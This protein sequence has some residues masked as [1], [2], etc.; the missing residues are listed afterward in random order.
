MFLFLLPLG[1]VCYIS[2]KKN[3]PLTEIFLVYIVFRLIVRLILL[4][5]GIFLGV[6]AYDPTLYITYIDKLYKNSEEDYKLGFAVIVLIFTYLF[7]IKK[8]SAYVLLSTLPLGPL[9]IKAVGD[10]MFVP[11]SLLSTTFIGEESLSQKG[12]IK[13]RLLEGRYGHTYFKGKQGNLIH[14][15]FI[16]K[17]YAKSITSLTFEDILPYHRKFNDTPV[18][19]TSSVEYKNC[20]NIYKPSQARQ[21]LDNFYVDGWFKWMRASKVALEERLSKVNLFSLICAHQPNTDLNSSKVFDRCREIQGVI[22]HLERIEEYV[23]GK[24]LLREPPLTETEEEKIVVDGDCNDIFFDVKGKLVSVEVKLFTHTS[25]ENYKNGKFFEKDIPME[26]H[27][28]DKVT[29]ETQFSADS[30]F[31]VIIFHHTPET[32]KYC[33]GEYLALGEREIPLK[34]GGRA[35]LIVKLKE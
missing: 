3:R 29:K 20:L 2:Y 16:H 33:K 1:L 8:G 30:K 35:L 7:Q 5:V 31:Q 14:V 26:K 19:S 6:I 12:Q 28:Y 15:N 22:E 17:N 4:I 10:P 9:L 11:K 27:Y 18:V 34:N 25:V 21:T 13:D 24:L 23:G 32:L